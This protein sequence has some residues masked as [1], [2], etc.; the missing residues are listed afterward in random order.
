MNIKNLKNIMKEVNQPKEFDMTYV[1]LT[2]E[3][4]VYPL[5]L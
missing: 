4:S 2:H 5:G 3:L 1:N